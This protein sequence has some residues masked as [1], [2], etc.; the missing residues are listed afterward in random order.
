MTWVS[1]RAAEEEPRVSLADAGLLVV[2]F[3]LVCLTFAVED[4]LSLRLPE[5]EAGRGRAEDD[6]LR[7]VA[8]GT[9][10]VRVNGRACD[11][12]DVGSAVRAALARNRDVM[13]RVEA[14]LGAKAAVV[15]EVLEQV[16]QSGATRVSLNRQ[17]R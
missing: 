3:L 10:E 7:I 17:R 15:S 6:W 11:P 8:L 12:G 2:A 14:G 9:G 13:V 16:R 5:G 4:G 1:A